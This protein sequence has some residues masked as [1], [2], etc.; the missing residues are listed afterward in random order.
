MGFTKQPV[1]NR[2]KRKCKLSAKQPE[3]LSPK[4][5]ANTFQDINKYMFT[6]LKALKD[7][8]QTQNY[9]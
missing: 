7:F 4:A 1:D 5:P 2:V 8:W 3:M 9:E 6:E